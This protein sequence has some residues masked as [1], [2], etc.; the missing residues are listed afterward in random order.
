[1]ICTPACD[2]SRAAADLH[3]RAS[4]LLRSSAENKKQ[5][6]RQ[7]QLKFVPSKASTGQLKNML[8]EIETTTKQNL[9]EI[10]TESSLSH[11]CLKAGIPI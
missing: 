8:G 4:E 7:V 10:E 9:G 6:Y 2:V 11:F 3:Q 5:V 1:M